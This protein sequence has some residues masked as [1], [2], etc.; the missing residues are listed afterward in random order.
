[1]AAISFGEPVGAVDTNVR[2]VLGRVAVGHGSRHD[3]GEP[4]P[5]RDL[6]ALADA[7]VATD[8]PADW[9]AALMDVGATLCLPRAP[10]C[11]ACPMARDCAFAAAA[12]G[13]RPPAAPAPRRRVAESSVPYEGTPRWLRGRLV[14]HLREQPDGAWTTFDGAM[15]V[16][17]DVAVAAALR[18]LA[19]DGLVEL[20]EGGRA[21]L[22]LR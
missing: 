19:R 3:P 18:A 14:A 10:R 4:L 13:A 17:D 9:T 12:A 11:A 7:L 8:R 21:R 16:H 5:G 22:P 1:M 2:R 20:D 6:Q 15:G